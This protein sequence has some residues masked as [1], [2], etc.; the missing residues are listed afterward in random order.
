MKLN[1]NVKSHRGRSP[2]SP[3]WALTIVDTT[4]TPSLG[5]F[6]IVENRTAEVLQPI[7]NEVVLPGSIIYTDEWKAYLSISSSPIY[8]HYKITHKYNFVDPS[9]GIHTQNIESYHN[10]IKRMI[11]LEKGVK[12][13]FHDDFLILFT[14]IDTYKTNL[15]EKMIEV[16]KI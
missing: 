8:S 4:I 13:G 11:K 6:R 12:K 1:Y 14:F 3:I 15:I 9:A 16:I 2:G 5:F 7:I 10:K